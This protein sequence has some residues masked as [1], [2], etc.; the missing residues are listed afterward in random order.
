MLEKLILVVNNARII[1]N[2][3]Q[4][5]RAQLGIMQACELIIMGLIQP[6]LDAKKANKK[7]VKRS[8]ITGT[9]ETP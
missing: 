8:Q 5:Q 6:W 4:P 3:L 7:S 9:R 2:A 1:Y